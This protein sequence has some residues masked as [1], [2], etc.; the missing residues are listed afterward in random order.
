MAKQEKLTDPRQWDANQQRL[1]DANTTIGVGFGVGALGICA[2]VVAG[3][4]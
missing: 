1:K 2:A 3:A 4:T